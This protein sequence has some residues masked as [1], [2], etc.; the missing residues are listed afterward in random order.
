[1]EGFGMEN[2]KAKD[3]DEYINSFPLDIQAILQ[4]IRN[5]VRNA[6]PGATEAIS[7]G[8]PAL[9]LNGILV[10]F[11]AQKHH[12]GF[13]PTSSGITA[14]QKELMPYKT[15]KGAVQFPLNKPIP[16]QLI[17]KITEFRAKQALSRGK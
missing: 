4:S 1:M 2:P 8:M 11:A 6:A 5:T 17:G 16:Y 15:S 7:Y 3:I 9:K 13:Y 10:F 14:F 12:I